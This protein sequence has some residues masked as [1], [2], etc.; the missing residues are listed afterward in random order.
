[1]LRIYKTITNYMNIIQTS[2]I[3]T[4]SGEYFNLT[5]SNA[6]FDIEVIAHALSN[7]CR[8]TGHTREFYSVAQH[9]VLCSYIDPDVKP[10]E[11]LMHDASEAYLGD[12]SSPL[13]KMI[14]DYVE[15]ERRIEKDIERHFWLEP[16]IAG[17]HSIGPIKRAD[18][19]MLLTE[20]RDLLPSHEMD[21]EEWLWAEELRLR[22][23]EQKIIP[24]PPGQAKSAFLSRFYELCPDLHQRALHQEAKSMIE[25][26]EFAVSLRKMKVC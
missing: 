26:P 4:F 8:F 25:S 10:F 16:D 14:P 7:I 11:K 22:P 6:G 2:T 23:L 1:M 18:L 13:K 15:I 19:I 21:R 17:K 9:C 20:K 3:Q 5:E 24:L 12:V